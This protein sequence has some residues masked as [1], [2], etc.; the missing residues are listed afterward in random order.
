[1]QCVDGFFFGCGHKFPCLF[2]LV[3]FFVVWIFFFFLKNSPN[4]CGCEALSVES[5]FR[6]FIE[7]IKQHA[8]NEEAKLLHTKFM[9]RN[10]FNHI[11]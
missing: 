1:M 4:I 9:E 7:D 6:I 8:E 2:S 11:T 10:E 3:Y 5:I